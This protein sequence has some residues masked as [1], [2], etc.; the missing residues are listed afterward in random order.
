MQ[1]QDAKKQESVQQQVEQLEN[2]IKVQLEIAAELEDAVYQPQHR[3]QRNPPQIMQPI[4]R[5]SRIP[6]T[7]AD[8][9]M[10]DQK[11]Q[12][13]SQ[14]KQTKSNYQRLKPMQTK[15]EV[16]QKFESIE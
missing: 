15:P 6:I 2:A 5:E 16:W 11:P 1:E 12:T 4:E 7:E 14:T 8:I 13:S 3:V 10:N 9:S